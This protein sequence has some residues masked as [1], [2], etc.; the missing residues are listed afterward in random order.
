MPKT[1]EDLQAEN[2]EIRAELALSTWANFRLRAQNEELR[3]AL[4]RSA[5]R[6]NQAAILAATYKERTAC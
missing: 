4:L 5:G 2:K 1:Y 6:I 3:V